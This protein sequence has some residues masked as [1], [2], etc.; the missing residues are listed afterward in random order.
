VDQTT[1]T[2][3]GCFVGVT[4]GD[5]PWHPPATDPALLD[6]EVHVWRAALDRPAPSLRQFERLLAPVELGRA[7]RR[8]AVR[9][10][11]R[12]IAAHGLL[13][14][15]LS[16]Y[17]DVAP[18]RLRFR[19]NQ[20][21]KPFLAPPPGSIPLAFNMAHSHGLALYAVAR[22]GQVGIDLQRIRPDI[23]CDRLAR[24]FCCAAGRAAL[25]ALPA[26]LRYKAFFVC[27]T[28]KEAYLKARGVGL[29]HPPGQVDVGLRAGGPPAE[30]CARMAL[31]RADGWEIRD[32][33]PGPGYTGALAVAGYG[34]R[35]RCW[36]L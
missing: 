17:L 24:W 10:Q 33:A 11:D 36:Q 34:W 14:V 16:R 21:G 35:L 20:Y 26:S 2:P 31:Y 15:I 9:D 8:C 27:W 19:F 30:E 29:A 1:S 18:A 32:L 13:R 12:F 3:G 23:D 28:R 6:S 7:R 5:S 22:S 25:D 4:P